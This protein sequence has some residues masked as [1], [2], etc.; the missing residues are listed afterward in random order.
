[1]QLPDKYRE[2]WIKFPVAN[3]ALPAFTV[4]AK[5]RLYFFVPHLRPGAINASVWRLDGDGVVFRFEGPAVAP[6][7]LSAIP[8][9]RQ[10]PLP[11]GWVWTWEPTRH[12]AAAR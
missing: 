4:G 12:A 6:S 5:R 1:M 7:P 2:G 10:V 8:R 11:G 9:D 3:L